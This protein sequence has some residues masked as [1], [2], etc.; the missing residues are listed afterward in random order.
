MFVEIISR[1]QRN[2]NNLRLNI[3]HHH[4]H[5]LPN[6]P[7]GYFKN[8]I[9]RHYSEILEPQSTKKIQKKHHTQNPTFLEQKKK[10]F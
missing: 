4:N 3:C 1:N 10:L 5:K 8:S 7:I 2:I 6:Y 9:Y